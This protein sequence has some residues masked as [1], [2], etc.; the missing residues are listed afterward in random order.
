MRAVIA[1]AVIALVT[2]VFGMSQI[3]PV[4][5]KTKLMKTR[6]VNQMVNYEFIK[7]TIKGD[8]DLKILPYTLVYDEKK[9]KRVIENFQTGG[10]GHKILKG[11]KVPEEGYTKQYWEGVFDKDFE[12]AL[13]GARN[14]IPE[15]TIDP[16][17]FGILVEMVYQMGEDGVKGFTKAIGFLKKKEYSLAADQLLYNYNDDGS[18]KGLTKWHNQT[19]GRA[20]RASDR[21]LALFQPMSHT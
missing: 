16:I 7:K 17:A 10:Y 1:L 8:E 14:I 2:G 12:I 20:N 6:L 11:E 4:M 21:L 5:S 18:Q 19:D 13:N 9:G 3:S 15:D